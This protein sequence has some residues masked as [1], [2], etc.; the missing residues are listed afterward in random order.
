MNYCS[1]HDC[2]E[3]SLYT[4]RCARTGES[5]DVVVCDKHA[6]G[7]PLI[8]NDLVTAKSIPAGEQLTCDFYET[9]PK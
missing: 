3:R 7:M 6:E 1:T 8:D 2:G 5:Q 9:E 4:L